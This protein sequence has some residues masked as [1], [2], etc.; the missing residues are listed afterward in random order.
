MGTQENQSEIA[1]FLRRWDEEAEAIQ[2]GLHGY[3]ITAQ[4]DIIQARMQSFIDNNRIDL[5]MLAAKQEAQNTA[6]PSDSPT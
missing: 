4:H 5:M 2:Q 6:A 1:K 3:A